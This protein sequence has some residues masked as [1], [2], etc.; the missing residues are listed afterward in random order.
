MSVDTKSFEGLDKKEKKAALKKEA[1]KLGISYEEMK[2]KYKASTSKARKSKTSEADSLVNDEQK[3]EIN[4]YKE[5][6]K[7]L[8]KEHL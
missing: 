8:D 5:Y 3:Q 7:K 1:E 4:E 2:K 6:T